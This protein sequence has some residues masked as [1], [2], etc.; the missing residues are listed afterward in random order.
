MRKF[1]L[2][3]ILFL[4]FKLANAQ[5]STA[6]FNKVDDF[7]IKNIKNG[8]VEY[9]EIKKNPSD[10][11]EI[12]KLISTFDF[13]NESISG[14][15]AFLINAYNISVIKIIIAKFPIKS[16]LDISGF[17]D[18]IK[19]DVF[20]K[21]MTLNDIENKTIR[22]KYKDPRFHFA[23]VCGAN[24]CPS[25]TNKGYFP[26]TVESQLTT[27]TRIAI[28]NPNFI[29]VN[30]E[31]KMVKISQLFEWYKDDF[32]SKGNDYIDFLNKYRNE[33]IPEN[34]KVSIY[35]YDWNLNISK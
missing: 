23:L 7:F 2:F 8:K 33:K 20:Q 9:D 4:L 18:K 14:Q 10:L 17:F 21:K 30:E 25:I 24:G 31:M 11:N 29:K 27:Q 15:K 19:N 16:P 13:E 32:I 6:F 28:N 12:V 5:N 26:S 35:T 3:T 1:Q 34:F 22:A